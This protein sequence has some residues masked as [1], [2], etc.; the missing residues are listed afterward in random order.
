LKFRDFASL[1][2]LDAVF[3]EIGWEPIETKGAEMR[4]KC[5]DYW[6]LHKNG[7]RT[8]KFFFNRN[9]VIGHCF[10]CGKCSLPMMVE[11]TFDMDYSQALN[12]LYR[13]TDKNDDGVIAHLESLFR[14]TQKEEKILPNLNSVILDKWEGTH[15]WFAG[16]GINET[17]RKR[18]RLGFSLKALLAT[19][20]N[21]LEGPAIILPHFWKANLVGWQNRWLNEGF[22]K[23]SNTKA[24]PREDTIWGLDEASLDPQAPII[25]ESITTALKLI[26]LGYSAIATFGA[27]VTPAQAAN[28]KIFS[29]GIILAPDN[30]SAGALWTHSIY[31]E[32]SSYLPIWQIPPEGELGE[33]IGDSPELIIE[34]RVSSMKLLI[35]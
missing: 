18:F 13:F 23:Y 8:G 28:L 25:V 14:S 9:K 34:D 20:E 24:F 15:E 22:P 31:D 1:I 19:K 29:E 33:D 30:D 3:E 26:S 17:T 10:V 16:R 7:D 5:P 35:L 32:L 4:G 11:A 12:W 21:I 6:D 2:D 27:R